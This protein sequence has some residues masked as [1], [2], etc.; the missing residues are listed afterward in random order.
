MKHNNYIQLR[1]VN[2]TSSKKKRSAGAARKEKSKQR[3]KNKRIR[4]AIN[5][6]KSQSVE[7]CFGQQAL[8]QEGQFSFDPTGPVLARACSTISVQGLSGKKAVDVYPP[9]LCT[10]TPSCLVPCALL[11]DPTS[12]GVDP[13]P[14]LVNLVRM[15]L[16]DISSILEPRSAITSLRKEVRIQPTSPSQQLVKSVQSFS[17]ILPAEN[18]FSTQTIGVPGISRSANNK[19]AARTYREHRLSRHSRKLSQ[20][21]KD[22]NP[23][24]WEKE[25]ERRRKER[26]RRHQIQSDRELKRTV[27]KESRR[28]VIASVLPDEVRARPVA[29]KKAPVRVDS[30]DRQVEFDCEIKNFSTDSDVDEL[31]IDLRPEDNVLFYLNI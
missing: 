31:H 18:F 5:K 1:G 6:A 4:E 11:K 22:S 10:Y 16:P 12:L 28:K 23:V 14:D 25:C 15:Q 19:F 21:F 13:I 3:R 8:V 27:E 24:K 9:E 20:L 30:T 2:G 7:Y 26:L 17:H 29:V